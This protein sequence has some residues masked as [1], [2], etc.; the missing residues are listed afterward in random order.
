MR[1]CA[2]T[3][4]RA[5]GRHGRRRLFVP[6]ERARAPENEAP[7]P[8]HPR[9]R[10]PAPPP[11]PPTS[12]TMP[13]AHTTR[14]RAKRRHAPARAAAVAA[15][16]APSLHRS[17][18]TGSGSGKGGGPSQSVVRRC[19]VPTASARRGGAVII[20]GRVRRVTSP[21]PDAYPIEGVAAGR[22]VGRRTVV[23]FSNVPD[24]RNVTRSLLPL[25]YSRDYFCFFFV[26]P[27]MSTV[28]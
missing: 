21:G 11:P 16:Q 7:R 22:A 24:V 17:R 2:L 5:R 28:A 3:A 9:K 26:F 27:I 12:K 10:C 6:T 15:V 1:A 23:D 13:R 25:C 20:Y 8:R 18:S 4:G 14:T 19:V